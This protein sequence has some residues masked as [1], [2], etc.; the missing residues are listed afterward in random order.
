MAK[1]RKILPSSVVLS[2][3]V[4]CAWL[5][6]SGAPAPAERLTLQAAEA[7]GA[8]LSS[9]AVSPQ[10]VG[11]PLYFIKN[12]G[13]VDRQARFYSQT[14]R[15]T[16][17]FT[18]T[19]LVF[20]GRIAAAGKQPGTMRRDVSRLEFVGANPSPALFGSDEQP[21]R[22]NY[23]M[24]SDRSQWRSGIQS[25]AAVAYGD[26][27]ENIDLRVYG[28]ESRI[29]YDWEVRPGGDPQAIR[30]AYRGARRTAITRQGDL[31]VETAFG[32]L[33]HKRPVAYQEVDGARVQVKAAF[34][35]IA[36]GLYGFAVG[37]YDRALTLTIDPLVF[38]TYL[39][40]S[41]EDA[42]TGIRIVADSVGNVYIA[43]ETPNSDFPTT[44]GAFA[45]SYDD[46]PGNY[47]DV[48]V[49]KMN[50]SGSAL[51]YSTFLGGESGDSL[52]GLRLGSGG[53]VY[54]TGYTMSNDF[55]TT[56]GAYQESKAGVTDGFITGLDPA[57][58]ALYYSTYL[59][60]AGED[61]CLGLVMDGADAAY[62]VGTTASTAFPTTAGAFDTSHNG[63]LDTFV[64]KFDFTATPLVYST[65][66]G[67][68]GED[69]G[70]AISVDGDGMAAVAG[71]TKSN[72]FPTTP[73][74]FATMGHGPQD[75]FVTKLD[76]TGTG[77]VYSTF[78]GGAGTDAAVG[79]VQDADK[80]AYV[81]GSTDSSDF[82]TTAGAFDTSYETS[83]AFVTKLNPTGKGLVYSTF[84]DGSSTDTLK[85]ITLNSSRQAIVTGYT[86]SSDFPTT[87]GAADVSFGG[88]NGDAFIT[89]FSADGASLVY[90]T[91]LGGSGFD[92]SHAIAIESTSACYV[93]GQTSSDSA[94]FPVTAGAFSTTLNGT[95]DAFVAKLSI[96][97]VLTAT[98]PNGGEHWTLGSTKAITWNAE[99]Y[100]GTV[101][102]VL[103]KGGSRFGNI[104]TGLPAA[105]G[106]YSW[107]VGQTY[108]HGA[109]PAGS[110]Y[111]FYLRSAD[112]TLVDRSDFR[113][114]LIS[115][116]QLQL[117]S[118]NGGE[119]WS[120]G[121]SHA[122]TWKAQSGVTGTV[123]LVLFKNNTKIG[124]ITTGIDVAVKS[125][126]WVVGQHAGGT[127]P[128]GELYSIR[129][130]TTDGTESDFSDG[131]FTI[132]EH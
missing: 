111:H 45:T 39:G 42:D 7:P 85:G 56:A 44:A 97:P 16:L 118:P 17:W 108:D 94:T 6:L 109:A 121:S 100:A 105:S 41:G 79:I 132:S 53:Y 117:T 1:T 46:D 91:F 34:K 31:R 40:G 119:N 3:T 69:A 14:R 47:R 110:D 2:M 8:N 23:F 50:S 30:F 87:P 124:Q 98:A 62:V 5:L 80:N 74:A 25:F 102:L 43:G 112:N 20:D 21:Y 26:I 64:L 123:R 10:R 68:A 83:G 113:F 89:A 128:A 90:S 49:T 101:R 84:L 32:E 24:G 78:L 13:Q 19:G 131:P 12:Q 93:T 38:C 86:M 59:G 55:P 57:G 127:A 4:L 37:T 70:Q 104:A 33:I 88:G 22:V 77:L 92:I 18:Q 72:D 130:L 48:F 116:S 9:I 75:A 103:F 115:P 61:K 129:I 99:N 73:G 66:V 107:T 51:V 82:P 120:K 11:L 106:S 122:I 29:E 60:G 15:Y 96:A 126:T 71:G 63:D 114:S 67:G 54:L 65:F 28:V 35:K 81:G 95:A 76:S 27:Y 36:G 52:T 58:E 125:Y